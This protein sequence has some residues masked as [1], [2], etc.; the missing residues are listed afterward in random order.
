[1]SDCLKFIE[2]SADTRRQA[3]NQL[4]TLI[5]ATLS[6]PFESQ[7]A[8]GFTIDPTTIAA[9]NRNAT[10]KLEKYC[11]ERGVFY[12]T[13]RDIPWDI[14]SAWFIGRSVHLKPR[15]YRKDRNDI[16]DYL[17]S[18]DDSKEILRC[19][20]TLNC[21]DPY[22][23]EFEDSH[24]IVSPRPLI[25]TPHII[26]KFPYED[27]EIFQNFLIYKSKS[28]Y[29]FDLARVLRAAL[30]TGLRPY[31]WRGTRVISEISSSDSKLD[32]V[33]LFAITAKRTNGRANYPIRSIDITD[34]ADELIHDIQYCSD[35]SYQLQM[36]GEFE[37]EFRDKLAKLMTDTSRVI[38]HHNPNKSYSLYSCRHQACANWRSIYTPIEVATLMGH[39]LPSTLRSYSSAKNAWQKEKLI[40]IVKPTLREVEAIMKRQEMAQKN[41]DRMA[42]VNRLKF[43]M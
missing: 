20:G 31:E 19:I 17:C 37:K 3:E 40:N 8:L 34:L 12:S 39:A 36:N 11:R 13:P 7:R 33:Y 1:M 16:V 15:T 24:D 38:W 28:P 29:A 14:F 23:A 22:D 42:A 9:R 35:W 5:E 32:R 25:D 21:V 4:K 27:F 26:K 2:P 18:L 10:Q 30:A 6:D 43:Q 41:I